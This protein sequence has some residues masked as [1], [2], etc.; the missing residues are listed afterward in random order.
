MIHISY[1][2][3][4][5]YSEIA[6]GAMSPSLVNEWKNAEKN[7]CDENKNKHKTP[8]LPAKT[9]SSLLRFLGKFMLRSSL[10]QYTSLAI[11]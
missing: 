5:T 6:K 1:L 7:I 4:Q 3:K 10:L 9:N 11:R 2:M 8:S